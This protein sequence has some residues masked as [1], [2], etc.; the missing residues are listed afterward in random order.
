M[1][2]RR[3][4]L[5]VKR[6]ECIGDGVDIEQSVDALAL[7]MLCEARMHPFSVDATVDHAPDGEEAAPNWSAD[8]VE[9]V[10]RQYLADKSR[11]E[12]PGKLLPASEQSTGSAKVVLATKRAMRSLQRAI[13]PKS[14]GKKGLTQIA[15]ELAADDET[16]EMAKQIKPLV[17]ALAAPRRRV[18]SKS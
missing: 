17:D 12:T 5:A 6:P 15:N 4:V 16:V 10:V 14:L 13:G 9:R 8:H 2:P 3:T 7:D 18:V 1:R 11:A